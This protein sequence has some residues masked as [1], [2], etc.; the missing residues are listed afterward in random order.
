MCYIEVFE[1]E[2]SKDIEGKCF[3]SQHIQPTLSVSLVKF[4]GLLGNGLCK[5]IE[6]IESHM[7]VCVCE[8]IMHLPREILGKQFKVFFFSFFF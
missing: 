7:D 2:I 4:S 6:Y 1:K 8:C 3:A 5:N